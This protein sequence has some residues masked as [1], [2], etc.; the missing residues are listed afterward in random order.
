M[1]TFLKIALLGIA[2]GLSDCLAGFMIGNL[3]QGLAMLNVGAMVLLYNALAFG[4]QVPAGMWVD[5]GRNAKIWVLIS[6]FLV[7]AAAAVFPFN[8]LAAIVLA[9]IGGAFFHVSGGKL[10]LQAFPKSTVGTGIFAAPGV[11][12][13]ALGGYLAW[14]GF[15]LLPI[16]LAGI[17]LIVCLVAFSDFGFDPPQAAS[18]VETFGWHDFLMLALLLAIAMRS[19][20]WN[21]FQLIHADAHNLLLLAGL[22]ALVGKVIGGFLADR[23]GWRNYGLLALVLATPLLA[24]GG[25]EPAFFLPGIMLLQ[26]ATPAA[27]LGMYQLLPKLPATAVGLCFGLAIAIGG[28]PIAM[29][30]EMPVFWTVFGFLPLAALGYWFGIRR[31]IN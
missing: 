9:G 8:A 13:L 3:P 2:H 21:L 14:Q 31:K 15:A 12:G 23:I 20:V 26:S 18:K 25:T 30:W 24:F 5:R 28:I 29:Q 7:L 10:A 16:L 6:L 17:A 22:A 11:M 19:A 4:G 1:K 27:V